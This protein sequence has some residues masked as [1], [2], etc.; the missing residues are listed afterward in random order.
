MSSR[1]LAHGVVLLLQ[2]HKLRKV[3]FSSFLQKSEFIRDCK[4]LIILN[5]SSSTSLVDPMM[6]SYSS[7]L[8]PS[9]VGKNE[10][11]VLINGHYVSFQQSGSAS[12]PELKDSIICSVIAD[13]S[14]I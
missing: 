7:K 10:S 5:N 1:A 6:I 2:E 11:G 3:A 8:R 9:A 4:C 14:S 13:E 12:I